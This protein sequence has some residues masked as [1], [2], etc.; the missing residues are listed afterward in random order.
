MKRFAAVCLLGLGL[1]LA[2]SC[3]GAQPPPAGG[4]SVTGATLSK[5]AGGENMP[6][7]IVVK[8]AGDPVSIDFRGD[9]AKGSVRVQLVDSAAKPVWQD[10]VATPGAFVISQTVTTLTMGAYSLGL[11]WDGPVQAQYSL[12]WRPRA[13]EALIISPLVLA[14]G[15]GMILVALGFAAYVLHRRLG[16]RFLLVGA[17]AW[18]VTVALKFAW[19]I[20]FN[21]MIYAALL[22]ALPA[23]VAI[24]VFEAYVGALTGIFEVGVTFLAVRFTRL[25]RAPWASALAFGIGFGVVEALLLGISP[26][27]AGLVALLAP[28]TFSPDQLESI[29][30]V[31]NPLLALA[32]IWERFFTIWVHILSNLL[33]FYAV[34]IRQTRWFWL[35]FAYKTAI[36]AVAAYA[37]LSGLLS[38]EY[39]IGIWI[40]EGIVALFGLAGIWGVRWLS[41][42]Y[43]P[44]AVAPI[45]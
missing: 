12:T 22:G 13:M 25:G 20:P 45:E 39:L 11:A 7:T 3:S 16:I 21:P 29:A 35:A 41:G 30:A 26:L 31:A 28:A 2:T 6:F 14:P 43:P 18:V 10:V 36:D 32:P 19:A 44:T 24:P 33:I 5:D 40:I 8:Q 4:A 34:A 38:N 42:R 9:L 27:T 17:L 23:S 15:I 37:Q 1:M